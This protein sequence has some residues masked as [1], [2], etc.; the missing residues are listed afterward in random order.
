VYA[1]NMWATEFL[2]RNRSEFQVPQ[3]GEGENP[4]K[5]HRKA[6][7]DFLAAARGGKFK[8]VAQTITLGA[9]VNWKTVRGENALMLAAAAPTDE[10]LLVM[11]LLA[12]KMISVD[13]KDNNGWTP[14]L[15]AV[16]NS[17]QDSVDFLLNKC[18]K[19][20]V[21]S[22]D[23]KNAAMLAVLDG[24]DVMAMHL[25]E[26]GV[27]MTQADK[28]GKPLL[29]YACDRGRAELVKWL[30]SKQA[31]VNEKCKD[32]T[33]ALMIS[34]G[35]GH[36]SIVKQLL[37]KRARTNSTN[38]D[39]NSALIISIQ[40]NHANLASRLI[41]FRADVTLANKKEETASDFADEARMGFVSSLI[42]RVQRG[43]DDN[44]QKHSFLSQSGQREEQPE[45]EG[46]M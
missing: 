16:R 2:A 28:N 42:A 19:L 9:D 27:S 7:S 43:D 32:N 17:N 24:N 21:R 36:T 44:R 30:L 25:I 1:A 14:L 39:G 8:R 45:Q 23:G 18:A 13:S 46:Q 11:D 26:K 38:N 15:H 4:D 31:N 41:E 3:G 29:F 34:A 12:Q 20:D 22:N 37:K 33:T 35:H 5:D 10:K 40:N 6:K